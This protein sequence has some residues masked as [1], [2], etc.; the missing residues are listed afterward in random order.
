MDHQRAGHVVTHA[1]VLLIQQQGDHTHAVKTREIVYEAE[2]IAGGGLKRS[3]RTAGVLDYANAGPFL[4][5]RLAFPN[6][7][8]NRVIAP[9]N[10]KA[11][12]NSHGGSPPPGEAS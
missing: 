8:K 4:A 11:R 5:W 7:F 12:K 1:A 9:V 10:N 3:D 6:R 2:E